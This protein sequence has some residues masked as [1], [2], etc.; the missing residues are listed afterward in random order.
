MGFLYLLPFQFFICQMK[1]YLIVGISVFLHL[2]T[3]HMEGCNA[4]GCSISGNDAA[5]G[6]IMESSRH[7]VGF[8]STLSTFNVFHPDF[9]GNRSQ[10]P[11]FN[12]FITHS[13]QG[14]IQLFKKCQFLLQLPWKESVLLEKNTKKH[15]A[16]LSDISMAF[17]APVF[18]TKTDSTSRLVFTHYLGIGAGIKLPTGEY[19]INEVTSYQIMPAMQPGSGSFDYFLFSNYIIKIYAKTGIATDVSYLF[20][21]PNYWRYKFGNKFTG[22]LFA[23]RKMNHKRMLFIPQIGF[24]YWYRQQDIANISKKEINPFTGGFFFFSSAA[25]EIQYRRWRGKLSYHYPLKQN[26][27]GNYSQAKAKIEVSFLFN[28]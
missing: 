27:G 4:C 20:T 24:Q 11:L 8:S 19:N 18:Q 3:Q 15:K 21:Q 25:T 5:Y 17:S 2:F 10:D 13:I 22:T 9:Y 16:G 14:K 7:L 23:F 1:Q 26:F 6:L 12:Y 28:F